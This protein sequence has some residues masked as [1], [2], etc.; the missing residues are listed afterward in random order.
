M[1]YL[2]IHL[3]A[4]T[5]ARPQNISASIVLSA[6]DKEGDTESSEAVATSSVVV[7]ATAGRILGDEWVHVVHLVRAPHFLPSSSGC[8]GGQAKPNAS[9]CLCTAAPEPI[10]IPSL[11]AASVSRRLPH[12]LRL[13][14]H[15]HTTADLKLLQ[16]Y[17]HL[18]YRVHGNWSSRSPLAP[19]LRRTLYVQ[20]AP[21]QPAPAPIAARAHARPR[22]CAQTF[23][24]FPNAR[25]HPLVPIAHPPL[26]S[27]PFIPTSTA[28]AD[29]STLLMY[30]GPHVCTCTLR[31]RG[32]TRRADGSG[33]EDQELQER[34]GSGR[35]K[36][37]V[38]NPF[39]S[40]RRLLQLPA[41]GR[42]RIP[43]APVCPSVAVPSR[44]S[45]LAS[46][47]KDLTPGG[48]RGQGSTGG[49]KAACLVLVLFSP[50]STSSTSAAYPIVHHHR[51]PLPRPHASRLPRANLHLAR[52]PLA[53]RHPLAPRTLAHSVDLP[54][55]LGVHPARPDLAPHAVLVHFDL[56]RA[57]HACRVVRGL[58][59]DPSTA[60]DEAEGSGNAVRVR[61]DVCVW[62]WERTFGWLGWCLWSG[63]YVCAFERAAAARAGSSQPDE[64]ARVYGKAT[65]DAARGRTAWV[66]DAR[67]TGNAIR[68]RE[69]FDGRAEGEDGGTN[70]DASRWRKVVDVCAGMRC[71]EVGGMAWFVVQDDVFGNAG[72]AGNSL[73]S[74]AAKRRW[75]GPRSTGSDRIKNTQTRRGTPTQTSHCGINISWTMQHCRSLS[76]SHH[77]RR[78]STGRYW[79]SDMATSAARPAGRNLRHHLVDFHSD[80]PESLDADRRKLLAIVSSFSYDVSTIPVEIITQIFL[81]CLPADV[82]STFGPGTDMPSLAGNSVGNGP[83]L[84]SFDF[85]LQSALQA[86]LEPSHAGICALHRAWCK[87]ASNYPLSLTLRCALDRFKLPPVELAFPDWPD[88]ARSIALFAERIGGPFPALSMLAL[89]VGS[90]RYMEETL[91]MFQNLPQLRHFRLFSGLAPSR[92]PIGAAPLTSLELRAEVSLADCNLIFQRFPVVASRSQ[93]VQFPP[94]LAFPHLRRLD[95]LIYTSNDIDI[96]PAF[97][98]R[99]A[100]TLTHLTLRVHTFMEDFFLLQCLQVLPLLEDLRIEYW[101]AGAQPSAYRYTYPPLVQMLQTRRRMRGGAP[102][103]SSFDLHIAPLQTMLPYGP[104][105]EKLDRLVEGGLHLRIHGPGLEWPEGQYIEEQLDF[106]HP[107]PNS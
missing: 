49:V 52:T 72:T 37:K 73:I 76:S 103:L 4:S 12:E 13:A 86:H 69:G 65:A 61:V 74:T 104:D 107:H 35:E 85:T 30:P 64:S 27:S 90:S 60:I 5:S 95:Y 39:A 93:G 47:G 94:L 70:V 32:P 6:S 19:P 1:C 40:A 15:V 2:M 31:G 89:S 67:A 23:I 53:R 106:P 26:S 99:S 55:D 77:E 21:V 97:I 3:P 36:G 34:A 83:T 41:T 24:F 98:G 91:R 7:V 45:T 71:Q 82:R 29:A 102:R 62:E 84:R 11:R 8:C 105:A 100:R 10:S 81:E 96:L 58:L 92:V 43:S 101:Q 18:P 56:A 88:N 28:V 63:G 14:L 80:V 33:Y 17:R 87:R 59:H 20:P 50:T 66:D 79:C 16:T 25:V 42:I 48:G 78:G 22:P 44:A 57:P 75:A 9:D 38:S 46:Y 68:G 54:V 51:F